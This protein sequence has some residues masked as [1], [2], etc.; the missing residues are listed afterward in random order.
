M[1]KTVVPCP[2]YE[3]SAKENTQHAIKHG[4]IVPTAKLGKRK[5]G[6]LFV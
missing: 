3:V 2:N 4:W 1:W 6:V 5:E